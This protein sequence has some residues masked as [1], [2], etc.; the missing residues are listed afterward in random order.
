MKKIKK[1]K[2]S[3]EI[4]ERTRYEWVS[5]TRSYLSLARIGLEELKNKHYIRKC[6]FE[7]DFEYNNK[8]LLIPIIFNIKHSIELIIK[9]LGVNI[10]KKYAWGHNLKN[11]I[12][13]L[14]S[15]MP[16]IKKQNKIKEFV[17]LVFKY[18]KCKFWSNKIVGQ[19]DIIDR[20]NDIFRFPDNDAN[21][22]LDLI[23]FKNISQKETD[24]LLNDIKKL[25]ALLGILSSQISKTKSPELHKSVNGCDNES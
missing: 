8:H 1:Q 5:F 7:Y 20:K 13:D 6:S 24:E 16:K 21:F 18:Y 23:L 2:S 3:S 9:S 10:D 19:S 25:N 12:K 4:T 14:Q 17:K 11:L 15:K 22:I